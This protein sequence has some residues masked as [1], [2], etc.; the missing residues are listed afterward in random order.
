MHPESMQ[1]MTKILDRMRTKDINLLDVGSYDVNG[2]YR[3]MVERRG[4][5]Y[6]GLDTRPGPN[7]DVVS[8]L[9]YNFPFE[10]GLFDI[11][12]SGSTM[13][14]VT[15]LWRWTPELARLVKPGGMVA[16]ITHTSWQ[17]HPSPLDCWRI[18]P[19]G[20]RALLDATGKLERYEIDMYCPTDISAVAYRK[21]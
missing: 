1:Q 21:E 13:E 20:M 9:P 6:I 7:V 19:D 12:I 10:D 15:D 5:G 2:S 8:V 3:N 4:W 18:M 14:H 16:I 11:V 17:Y